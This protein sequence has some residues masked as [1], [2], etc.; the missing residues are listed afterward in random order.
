MRVKKKI[1][2][3]DEERQRGKIEKKLR[4]KIT[5]NSDKEDRKMTY[6]VIKREKVT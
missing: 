4:E 6:A 3:R 1:G 5:K 2:V